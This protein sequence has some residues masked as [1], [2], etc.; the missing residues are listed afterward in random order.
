MLHVHRGVSLRAPLGRERE[1][2]KEIKRSK[3]LG[4]FQV[5][6][7]IYQDAGLTMTILRNDLLINS[8]SDWERSVLF[9]LIYRR[10]K[11][12]GE[13]KILP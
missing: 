5:S 2:A 8:E 6:L 3:I 13:R 9:R 12:H 11:L 7:Q 1:G 4:P 10:I